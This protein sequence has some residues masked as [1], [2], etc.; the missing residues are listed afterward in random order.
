MP[1]G[2]IM[3]TYVSPFA[4][5]FIMTGMGLGL[6]PADF[7]RVALMPRPA[8]AGL[9]GQL[10][11][12][13]AL[14]FLV[15]AIAP[16]EPVLAVG[17]IVIASCPGGVSSNAIVFAIKADLALSVTLTAIAS[18]VTVFTIPILVSLALG[19]FMQGGDAPSLPVGRTMQRLFMIT[20][21]PVSLGMILRAVAPAFAAKAR[22]Y[23]RP[24]GIVVIS[25]LIGTA[26]YSGFDFIRANFWTAAPLSFG[27][28]ATAILMGY[29]IARLMR[30]E[31]KQRTTVAVEVGVQNIVIAVFITLSLMNSR[32]LAAMPILYGVIGL[33]NIFLFL[34][35]TRYRRRPVSAG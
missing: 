24:A 29:G 21:L 13:P 16:L 11:L 14:A 26:L 34:A 15:A 2:E 27:F 32:E 19:L 7:R 31:P 20:V 23:F 5:A 12:L 8:I 17:L 9:A 3:N 6:T 18:L 35:L 4:L 22:K 10:L 1:L 30:L 28:T 25:A 33:I